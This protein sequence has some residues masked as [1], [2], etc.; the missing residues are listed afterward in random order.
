MLITYL[1]YNLKTISHLSHTG[2]IITVEDIEKL[3]E[4]IRDYDYI[5][6]SMGHV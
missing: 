5:G 2:T 4:V 6:A 1:K 3:E